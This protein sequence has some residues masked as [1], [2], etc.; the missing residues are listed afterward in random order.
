M[1]WNLTDYV[2]PPNPDTDKYSDLYDDVM[3]PQSGSDTKG[4]T[5]EIGDY[6]NK[7]INP[8]YNPPFTKADFGEEYETVFASAIDNYRVS[9]SG[10]PGPYEES[11]VTWE[12]QG[13]TRGGMNRDFVTETTQ[14]IEVFAGDAGIDIATSPQDKINNLMTKIFQAKGDWSIGG[15]TENINPEA[16]NTEFDV[17]DFKTMA[18]ANPSDTGAAL[19]YTQST[20]DAT[21]DETR[22]REDALTN[23]ENT[24]EDLDRQQLDQQRQF[25]EDLRTGKAGGG[26]TGVR[27]GRNFRRTAPAVQNI[28]LQRERARQEYDQAIDRTVEDSIKTDERSELNFSN[29]IASAWSNVQ[30]NLVSRVN[31][32][33]TDDFED[34]LEDKGMIHDQFALGAGSNAPWP[35]GNPCDPGKHWD[36]DTSACVDDAG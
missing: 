8:Q 25:I 21:T 24:T 36:K 7:I 35:G 6:W 26:I 33:K 15:D 18:L 3:Q 4:V 5:T 9:Q 34:E 23:L 27:T 2:V 12:A 28:A 20:E 1:G 19:A 30:N 14:D 11:G 22:A 17:E 16:A 10:S 31:Q 13:N 29:S 32:F